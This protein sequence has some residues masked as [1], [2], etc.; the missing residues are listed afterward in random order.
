MTFFYVIIKNVVYLRHNMERIDS[1]ATFG[2][3]DILESLN[4]YI[5][6]NIPDFSAIT[7]SRREILDEMSE[8]IL[9]TIRENRPVNLTFICTHNSR[10]SHMSRLWA[11]TAACHFKVPKINC[12]S[13]GTEATAF[14]PRAIQALKRAGFEIDRV[15]DDPNPVYQ[16]IFA[17]GVDRV[18]AF[19]KK[20]TDP[21][22][23]QENFAAVLT[24]S[25]AD[26]ACPI[27]PGAEIRFSIPFED[28]KVADNTTE[29]EARYDE[30]CFQIANE[31]FYL[32][33][34]IKE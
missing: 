31:M 8:Y 33:S 29:E 21:I 13:G 12:F 24:C 22:N 18:E 2:K 1:E 32:F 34:N 23:P 5:V 26:K 16:I 28:P 20:F 9:E 27:V 3:G 4:Q 19:S 25:D 11:Q 17:E 6:S 30:R 7:E 15:T 14:N 10:R